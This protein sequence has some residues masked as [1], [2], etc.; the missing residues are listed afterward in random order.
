MLDRQAVIAYVK[1]TEKHPN[2]V[3]PAKSFL[4]YRCQRLYAYYEPPRDPP[5]LPGFGSKVMVPRHT[6][7]LC[8]PCGLHVFLAGGVPVLDPVDHDD[9]RQIALNEAGRCR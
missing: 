7:R 8:G 6:L 9:L 4:C 3:I 5:R 2:F 1:A